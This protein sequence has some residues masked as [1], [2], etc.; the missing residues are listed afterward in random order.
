MKL[1]TATLRNT[2]WPPERQAG[3][4]ATKT[5]RK[6]TGTKRKYPECDNQAHSVMKSDV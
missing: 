4:E 1:K 2:P 5:R 6:E 3:T